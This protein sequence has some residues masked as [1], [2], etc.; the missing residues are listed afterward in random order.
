MFF[1]F[2]CQNRTVKKLVDLRKCHIDFFL[3]FIEEVEGE[4]KKECEDKVEETHKE[5]GK[6]IEKSM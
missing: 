3:L 1:K 6:Q 2:I 5:E 4:E